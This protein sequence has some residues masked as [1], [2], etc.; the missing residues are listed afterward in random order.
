MPRTLRRAVF[1]GISHERGKATPQSRSI[2]F[3]HD[4][5][6]SNMR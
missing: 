6:R 3:R 2:L 5:P 1:D 4:R